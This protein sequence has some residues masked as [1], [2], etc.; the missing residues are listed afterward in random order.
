MKVLQAIVFFLFFILCFTA[1]RPDGAIGVTVEEGTNMATAL[2]PD[3]KT[4]AISLQ[5]GIWILP[6]NG[7]EAE[8]ITD[9]FADAQEPCWSPDGE[10]VAFQ[11]YRDGNY[12]VWTIRKDGK[13]LT[14]HTFG[15]FDDREPSWAPDGKSIIFSS[16][17][18][19]NYDIW[20]VM[21]SDG[22]LKRLTSDEGNDS[23]PAFSSDGSMI[24]F[25]SDR[26]EAPGIYLLKNGSEKLFHGS[27][28]RVTAPSWTKNDQQVFFTEYLGRTMLFDDRNTSIV[29]A[30]S[31]DGDTAI[32]ISDNEEDVFPFRTGFFDDGAILYAADGKIKKRVPGKNEVTSIPFSATFRLERPAYERKKYDF[33]K[34][35]ERK[36]LGIVGPAISPD[37]K[38][39]AFAAIGNLYVQEI[40]GELK[41]ITD[42]QFVDIDPDWSPDGSRLAFTTDRD[43]SMKVWIYDFATSEARLL[44]DRIIGEMSFP[45]WS[46]D[47]SQVAFYV[48]DYRKRWGAAVLHVAEVTS[49]KVRQLAKGVAVPGKPSWSPDGKVIAIAALK[50]HSTRFREGYNQFLLINTHDGSTRWVTPDS[51]S[52]LSVRGE[53]GPVWSPDGKSIAYVNKGLLYTVPVDDTGTITGAPVARSSELA[54]NISW[55]R[56]SKSILYLA[57]DRLKKLSVANGETT[58]IVLNFQWKRHIPT[59]RYIV[60]AGRLITGVDSNYQSDMDI[61][62]EGNRIKKIEPAGNREPGIRVVDA[63][64]KVV[65]PG[66]FEMHTHQST[67]VGEK[68]G[69]IWL[70]YGITSV[71]EPGADP[72]E[73]L[74]RKEAWE[75]GV[76]PG[77]REFF[78]GTLMDGNR[79]AYGLAATVTD[80]RHVQQ[81][82]E[83]ARILDYDLIKTYVRMPDSVQKELTRGAHELGIP[84]SSHELY[85]AVGYG[86]DAIEH[87]SGTSRRGYSMLLDGSFR[88]YDDVIK[89]ISLSG[90]N[91]TPTLCLRTG[92]YRMAKE[93]DELLDDARIRKFISPDVMIVQLQQAARYDSTK[94]ARSDQNY[95]LLLKTI[96]SV[97]DA[98]G[99]VTAGTDAPFAL[100]GT[101]LHSELWILVEAGLTPY[102]ALRAGSL[103]AARAI[104]VEKDLGSIE[105]GKLADLVIVEGNP[106]ER[107]QDAMKVKKVVKNGVVFDVEQ[108]LKQ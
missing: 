3:S 88:S 99:K 92:F 44:T 17:R 15:L 81:E 79:I 31:I 96:K 82:L 39:I 89:L 36:A 61:Y 101:S 40:G 45:S 69:K 105:V 46:S 49:G 85:P 102:Q 90:A 68:L 19:G 106:L 78:T 8:R 83:R 22:S 56:D 42:D 57:T 27:A 73:A 13:E 98:G 28:L 16:D 52:S 34:S 94:T 10:Y 20:K 48:T 70:S 6:A 71:R 87:L 2:S 53:N 47:G 60:H 80:K 65:M 66:L 64:D 43:G 33:D 38:R 62:I 63:S 93:Y 55:T 67:G 37:G 58:E 54:D 41:K 32:Q 24:A 14:Q 29:Y 74:E 104:G 18:A 76:R 75:S 95:K 107:I 103:N 77:P 97:V 72:Y 84:T 59:E 5:G 9:E 7:G 30:K 108:W 23:N 1:C 86:V 35:E 100:L 26:K 50:A 12:H 25:V 91:I 51:T 4:I 21:L 11:S